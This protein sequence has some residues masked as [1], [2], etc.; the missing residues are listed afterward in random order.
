MLRPFWNVLCADAAG[1]VNVLNFLKMMFAY[2]LNCFNDYS[3]SVK[4]EAIVEDI[5]KC[6]G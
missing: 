3:L 6:N 5:K 4:N 2:D 1:A